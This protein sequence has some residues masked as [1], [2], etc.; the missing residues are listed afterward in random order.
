MSSTS[1][2]AAAEPLERPTDEEMFDKTDAG[3]DPEFLDNPELRSGKHRTVINLTSYM[4]WPCLPLPSNYTNHGRPQ[5][6]TSQRQTFS[7]ERS[8]KSFASSI[9]IFPPS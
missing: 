6:I 2:E 3:Y 1:D 4:V 8:M 7:R 9:L 5:S